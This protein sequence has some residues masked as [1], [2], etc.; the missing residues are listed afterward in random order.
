MW[1]LP[2]VYVPRLSADQ[3]AC[4]SLPDQ[5]SRKIEEHGELL[6]AKRVS[7][8]TFGTPM[9]HNMRNSPSASMRREE[10]NPLRTH[11]FERCTISCRE[12]D[13]EI[14]DNDSRCIVKTK[15]SER[16]DT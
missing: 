10:Q 3:K 1:D 6:K 16:C 9:C 2:S 13:L 4:D 7:V 8:T 14:K 15:R 12:G 5:H 11:F